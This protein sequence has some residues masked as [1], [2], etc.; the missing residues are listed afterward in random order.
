MKKFIGCYQGFDIY[1]DDEKDKNAIELIKNLTK[2]IED[3]R[4]DAV[5]AA[6]YRAT[7]KL[8]PAKKSF[9]SGFFS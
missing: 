9:I 6:M 5:D 3:R 2:D 7:V 1:L 8:K 4:N